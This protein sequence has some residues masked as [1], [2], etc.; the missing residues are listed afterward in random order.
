M[1]LSTH[2]LDTALGQPAAEIRVRLERGEPTAGWILV[3][4][5]S[6]DPDGRI[7][8]LPLTSPGRWRLVFD[9]SARS[10]FFPEV[11]IAFEVS[12]PAEPHHVPLLLAPYGYS[13]YRGS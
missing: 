10:A 13:T 5:A 6:T 7:T 12:D 9:T 2:V 3:A 11:T 8:G 1:G 4:E